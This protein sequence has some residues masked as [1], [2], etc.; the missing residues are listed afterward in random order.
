M[1]QLQCLLNLTNS[2]DEAP[3]VRVI[4]VEAS[5][6]ERVEKLEDRIAEEVDAMPFN[7]KPGTLMKLYCVQRQRLTYHQDS[8]TKTEVLFLDDELIL[9]L[10]ANVLK[11]AQQLVPWAFVSCYFQDEQFAFPDAIDV[12][13]AWQDADQNF[14]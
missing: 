2:T 8:T 1:P 11:S 4:V 7:A 6:D 9:R 14:A 5:L 12:V 3:T 13:A 10:D